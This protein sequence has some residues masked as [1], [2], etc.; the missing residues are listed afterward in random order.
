MR[1]IK[2]LA[3]SINCISI[4]APFDQI[5]VVRF[6]VYRCTSIC[7]LFYA[8]WIWRRHW[9]K[10]QWFR[11]DW[12]YSP[13][14]VDTRWVTLNDP[15]ECNLKCRSSQHDATGCLLVLHLSWFLLDLMGYGRSK[16]S[17]LPTYNVVM[18][19]DGRLHYCCLSCS[20][21]LRVR[22]GIYRCLPSLLTLRVNFECILK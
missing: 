14:L 3:K 22:V 15:V 4:A 17:G 7:T 19:N 5:N 16:S 11:G 8:T 12:Q 13:R 1:A 20:W 9:S 18:D 6:T 21:C 2:N 10:L